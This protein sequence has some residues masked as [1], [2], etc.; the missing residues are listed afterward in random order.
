[1][2]AALASA[3]SSVPTSCARTLPFRRR[4]RRPRGGDCSRPRIATPPP[5]GACLPAPDR[6]Q[7]HPAQGPPATR[8]RPPHHPGGARRASSRAG[9]AVRK[10][11]SATYHALESRG[12][13]LLRLVNKWN[14]RPMLARQAHNLK[15]EGSSPFP[16]TALSI[17][18]AFF[19]RGCSS[20]I[21][22]RN[23][24]GSVVG[25]G[26]RQAIGCLSCVSAPQS[27]S[28]RELV[29]IRGNKSQPQILRSLPELALSSLV[30]PLAPLAPDTPST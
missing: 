19:N 16:A 13:H 28:H 5:A 23:S 14:S 3:P 7:H 29:N 12:L 25:S 27:A 20:I 22:S 8:P 26:P 11:D 30:Y 6:R 1:M 10:L 4:V 15:V 21:R 9:S 24:H 18:K 2:L 17:E